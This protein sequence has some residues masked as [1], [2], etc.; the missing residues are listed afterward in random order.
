MLNLT[1][2]L[3]GQSV[4]LFEVGGRAEGFEPMIE[5]LFTKQGLF[6]NEALENFL[7]NSRKDEQYDKVRNI[8]APMK[9][10]TKPK[11]SAFLRFNGLEISYFELESILNNAYRFNIHPKDLLRSLVSRKEFEF[12]RSLNLINVRKEIPT[13]IGLPL[14][15]V[16]NGTASVKVSLQGHFEK[17]NAGV[18]VSGYIAPSASIALTGTI[19][20]GQE[21]FEQ[22]VKINANLFTH[23]ALD[24]QLTFAKDG[25]LK[26]QSQMKEEKQ[27][28]VDLKIERLVFNGHQEEKIPDLIEQR[29][30]SHFCTGDWV[31]SLLGV[32]F[33]SDVGYPNSTLLE[34]EPAFPLNGDTHITVTMEKTDPT[35]KA[36]EF[37]TSWTHVPGVKYDYSFYFDRVGSEM[38]NRKRAIA[39]V[40]DKVA[41]VALASVDFPEKQAEISVLWDSKDFSAAELILS[42]DRVTLINILAKL[43]HQKNIMQNTKEPYGKIEP[44]I[45][46]KV[47]N[48]REFHL[49]GI[50]NYSGKSKV[51]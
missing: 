21:D 24:A 19:S 50:I 7:K 15:L 48:V 23:T 12:T 51:F 28:I 40:Y 11:A 44:E 17:S 3:F 41:G 32:K 36:Y 46:F 6:E 13:L 27:T 34:N 38:S 33:C 10:I 43:N 45:K 25:K 1:V 14:Q 39:L 26:F 16:L 42:Y 20:M 4:N 47:L 9:K 5:Q 37:S 2:D 8:T 35:F 31:D 18:E 30:N 22:G 49:K 29:E